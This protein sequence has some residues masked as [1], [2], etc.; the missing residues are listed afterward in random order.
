M[1]ELCTIIW[2]GEPKPLKR[3]RHRTVKMKTGRE[4]IASYDPS[5]K[6]KRDF[7]LA[8][9]E[10]APEVPSDKPI[11]GLLLFTMPRSKSHYGTGKNSEIIKKTSFDKIPKGDLD[12]Y[13]KF[14]YDSMNKIFFADDKQI[15]GHIPIKRYGKMGSIKIKLFELDPGEYN[16]NTFINFP[17]NKELH[18]L[19]V[20]KKAPVMV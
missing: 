1:K 5:S 18:D 20:L 9:Q 19:A 4:F 17:W 12:N 13:E 16:T 7:L 15:V 14:I 3:H 8:V 2:R 11:I 6:D 10:S